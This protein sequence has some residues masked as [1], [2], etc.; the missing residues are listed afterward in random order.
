MIH[1][2]IAGSGQRLRLDTIG[3]LVAEEPA[4]RRRDA[5]RAAAIRRVRKWDDTARDRRRG[6]SAG[7]ARGV[8]E[9]PRVARRAEQL[10]FGV[11][12]L[13]DFWRIGL[14]ENVEP[15]LVRSR[16]DQ[17]IF[18]GREML[19]MAA[20]HGHPQ[21]RDRRTQV[22]DEVGNARERTLAQGGGAIASA[23]ARAVASRLIVLQDNGVERRINGFGARDCR[24]DQFPRADLAAAY[25]LGQ[26]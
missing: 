17:R 6:A 10:G 14:A 3:W 23:T 13:A 4:T 11:R 21:T 9:S 2:Q 7:T 5:D 19:E 15:G 24:I 22:L 8:V 16:D 20:T 18:S 26:T 1:R 25:K 12:H